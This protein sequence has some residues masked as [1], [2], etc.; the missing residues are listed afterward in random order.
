MSQDK[1]IRVLVAKMGLD[2]HDTGARVVTQILRDAGFEVI[3][4]GMHNTADQIVTS[5]LQEDVDVI[6]LSFLSGEHLAHTTNVIN[7]LNERKANIPVIVGG[8]IPRN[9]V[10]ELMNIGANK[11][12]TP[13][14][15]SQTIIDFFNGIGS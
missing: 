5:A 7:L 2:A 8:I 14:T 10:P 11:V 12:F 4:G 9:H 15:P 1:K 3:Y 6:G 13:G